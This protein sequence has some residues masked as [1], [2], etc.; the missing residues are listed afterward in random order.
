MRVVGIDP[1]KEGALALYDSDWESLDVWDLPTYKKRIGG[2]K[3]TKGSKEREE[4]DKEALI[5]LFN[6]FERIDLVVLEQVGQRPTSGA[7]GQRRAQTGMF[8]MGRGFGHLEMLIAVKNFRVEPVRPQIWKRAMGA[9]A[10]KKESCYRAD[11]LLPDFKTLWRGP[12]GG[13]IDGRAEAAMLALY[14]ATHLKTLH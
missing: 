9:P 3:G 2:A 4:F 8:E 10:E 12:R 7:P 1:G 13:G 5:A 14:G 6:G 11:Q